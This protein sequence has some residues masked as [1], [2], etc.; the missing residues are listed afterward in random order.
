MTEEQI[1]RVY[2]HAEKTP[3]VPCI[4]MLSVKDFDDLCRTIVCYS[5][6]PLSVAATRLRELQV[7]PEASSV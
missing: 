5:V 2:D 7:T 3:D 1:Q 6:T 4:L